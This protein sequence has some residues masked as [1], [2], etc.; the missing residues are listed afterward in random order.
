MHWISTGTRIRLA[1][2]RFLE[3]FMLKC[4]CHPI[5][6]VLCDALLCGSLAPLRDRLADLCG[7]LA[8]FG[9][10]QLKILRHRHRQSQGGGAVIL[11]D[12]RGKDTRLY[13]EPAG[14]QS[15]ESLKWIIS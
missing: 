15:Q 5:D 11:I 6:L 14:P 12:C 8:G 3:V 9:R 2:E 10:I 7:Y 1:A 4:G 13:S